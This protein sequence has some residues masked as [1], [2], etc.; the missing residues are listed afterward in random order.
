MELT[1]RQRQ[2]VTRHL[3]QEYQKAGK[4]RKGQLLDALIQLTGY[5]RSYAA[6]VLRQALQPCPRR[7]SKRRKSAIYDHQVL[8]AL[9]RVWAICDGI[10]GKRLAPFLPEIIPVLER[11]GEL[12]LTGEVRQ[13]L[14]TISAAT[15]DRLLA[16]VRKRYQLR[17]RTTAKPG[18]LLKHQIPIRTFS[19]W[20][21]A[22]PG[23]VE[24]DLVSHDGGT[25]GPDVI[26]T[27]DLTDVASGWTETQAVKN[28]AQVWVFEAL[29]QICA[30]LPFKLL[31]LDSDNGSE[32]INDQ[33]R[34]FCQEQQITFT[35]SRPY[36]KN[37]SCFVEQKNYSVVR[38]A[39]GYARYDT[40]E[41]LAVLNELY[42]Y[43]R[44]YTNYFQPVMKLVEKK[45]VG[46]RVQKRYDQ[47]KT[48]YRRLLESPH[49]GEAAK[50]GLEAEYAQ[51]NPVEL[52]RQIERLAVR[53]SELGRR[54]R[55]ARSPEKSRDLEYIFS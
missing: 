24:V 15:I 13:K 22:R 23:F 41:E 9:G 14:M 21:E 53:L 33:L 44:L 35:R 54:K 45:R 39:V 11:F 17:P 31:G 47:A 38:R 51:L 49:L 25:P 20:D 7:P 43:L 40:P 1:M 16:P 48:P 29:Q 2:A 34:R 26:Q 28:K 6:R 36:R 30:R 46:S 8:R 52:Q 55:A 5:R 50:R 18:T 37:D 3:A 12:S 19:D 27:L 32:F 42:G 4:K 10:C